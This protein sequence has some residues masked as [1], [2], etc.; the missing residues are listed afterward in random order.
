MDSS[1]FENTAAFAPPRTERDFRERVV[2][3]IE[4]HADVAEAIQRNL[5]SWG[6]RAFVA[7]DGASALALSAAHVPDAILLDLALPGTDGFEILEQMRARGV[8][9]PTVVVTA[10]DES[11]LRAKALQMEAKAYLVKPLD[12]GRLRSIVEALFTTGSSTTS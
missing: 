3:V 12:Y 7:L 9:A 2:L 6:F 8:T 1:H 4:D 10:F 5:L 11:R